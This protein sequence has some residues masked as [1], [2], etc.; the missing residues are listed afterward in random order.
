M[1][2]KWIIT[3]CAVVAVALLILGGTRMYQK[4]LKVLA[5]ND[6]V[7]IGSSIRYEPLTDNPVYREIAVTEFSTWTPENAMKMNA[8]QPVRG[9]FE[10]EEADT[11][12]AMAEEHGIRVRGHTLVWGESLPGWVHEQAVD[13]ASAK[14]ILK[15]HIQQVVSHYRGK[16]DA[17]DV[18]NEAW[19]EDGTLRDTIWLRTIG[20][21]YIPLA[22]QWTHE[23]DPEAELYYNDFENE[24]SNSKSE[25]M[26]QALTEWKEQGVPIDGIGMQMHLDAADPRFS[27]TA[28]EEQFNRFAEAGFLVA[29]TEM[30]VKLQ[31]LHS[32]NPAEVQAR[33]FDK[34]LEICL[35]TPSCRE[36]TV[37]GIKDDV[38]W[39]TQQESPEGR[40][41]LFDELG[42]P[43]EAY[44]RLKRTLL[45]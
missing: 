25:A 22:F 44:H 6:D 5:D 39:V 12:V 42:E 1:K 3:G 35:K 41:L 4:P 37:W 10:F 18:V 9:Q 29:V 26:L 14:Q 24:V 36:Y 33:R 45:F 40:P 30:D 27:P 15:E 43:K 31:N 20:P 38:S 28:I 8:L 21:E 17:W 32:D 13:A 34:V 2:K 23:A 11:I 7:Y 16:V 19:N